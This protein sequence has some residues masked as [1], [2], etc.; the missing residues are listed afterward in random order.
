MKIEWGWDDGYIA[1]RP[2]QVLEISDDDLEGL[3]EIEVNE[4]IDEY[5]KAAFE[6]QITYFWK[7]K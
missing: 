2:K 6:Q 5:V 7:R 1:A 3:T 4:V